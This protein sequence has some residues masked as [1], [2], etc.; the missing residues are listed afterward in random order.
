MNRRHPRLRRAGGL[1]ALLSLL[2]TTSAMWTANGTAATEPTTTV[3]QGQGSWGA[4]R[5]LLTWQDTMAEAKSPVDLK[6]TA[7]GSYLGRKDFLA[8]AVDYLLTGMPFTA[9]ESASVPGGGGVIGAPVHVSSLAGLLQRPVPDGF[10]TLELL[11]DPDD[12]EQP[13]PAACIVRKPYEGPVRIPHQNLAAMFLRYAGGLMPLSS[14]NHPGVLAAMGVDNFT[15][16]PLAGPAPVLRSDQDELNYFLQKYAATA[17]P[18]VWAGLKAIDTRIPWEPISERLGRTASAS[19]DGVEQQSQQLALGGGD[20]STGTISGFTAGVMAT[21]PASAMG[22]VKQSFPNAKTEFIEVQNAN[23]EWVAP[24]PE[25]LTKAVAAGGATPLHAL[26]NKV[27]GAYPLTWVSYLYA[28][29]KGLS[30]EKTEALA[31]VIR[32]LATAG[33][34]AAQPAGEGELPDGL[35]KQAL[36]AADQLVQS[37]CQGKVI[38]SDDPGDYAPDLPEM[39]AIGTM[40]RCTSEP[41]DPSAAPPPPPASGSFDS[42]TFSS[43]ASTTST[44]TGATTTAATTSS[45]DEEAGSIESV[46]LAATKLPL[47]FPS[48]ASGV[49]RLATLLIGA[50]LYFLLRRPVQRMLA[51]G[52]SA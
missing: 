16:P 10:V 42:G 51:R 23:G 36:A 11:C 15:T 14:W 12:P 17:A 34:K 43:G 4:Y 5:Q 25:S 47:P 29:A 7:H 39:K 45:D 48:G 49:D 46:A 1:V 30:L 26:T 27:P 6:Y 31:A 13:D 24:T 32:Y 22:G 20:P 8:G 9:A 19:R 35:R 41:K 33:Q 40:A 38:T 44:D 2:V 50:G 21:V 52:R 3:L 18:S 37:N 28:P